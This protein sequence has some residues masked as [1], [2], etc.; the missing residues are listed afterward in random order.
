M[1]ILKYIFSE[2]AG[3]GTGGTGG[4]G[5]GDDTQTWLEGLS[6]EDKGIVGVKG[7]ENPSSVINS[8]RNLEKMSGNPDNL[9]S[10]PG[11]DATPEDLSSYYTKL[12]RPEASNGYE[13]EVPEVGGDKDLAEAM[14]VIFF[15]AGLSKSQAAIIS[16]KWNEYQNGVGENNDEQY[17]LIAEEDNNDLKKEWGAKYD[18]NINIAGRAANEFGITDED[19][20]GLE[21]SLGFHRTMSLLQNI[22]ASLL[23]DTFESDTQDRQG[24]NVLSPAEARIKIQEKKADP[25]FTKRYIEGDT[26]AL[27]EMDRLHKLSIGKG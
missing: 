16:D 19:L 2:Q 13:I 10:I 25:A 15:E 3:D 4:D 14:K 5:T 24:F 1:F 27:A 26:L 21:E 18:Q 7:W 20:N 23:E 8:Y 6:D 12:G 11:E 9:V 17:N 22:G